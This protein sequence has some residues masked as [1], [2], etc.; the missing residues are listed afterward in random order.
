MIANRSVTEVPLTDI[1]SEKME[2]LFERIY[3][4]AT[5]SNISISFDI[6][7]RK[8]RSESIEPE[9]DHSHNI[10]I[11]RNKNIIMSYYI[12]VSSG[13]EFFDSNY[14]SER[15]KINKALV[16]VESSKDNK[17]LVIKL[18]FFYSIGDFDN[19]NKSDLTRLFESDFSEAIYILNSEIYKKNML[20]NEYN[21][22]L[23]SEIE[24]LLVKRI[25][26]EKRTIEIL[27]YFK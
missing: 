4:K 15:E 5:L 27:D 25:Q 6:K 1:L 19:M 16:F 23:R 17:S 14:S 8:F 18:E 7:K 22:K 13:I 11:E 9:F 3:S 26:I 2:V 24:S 21:Q 12:N 20:I 10:T